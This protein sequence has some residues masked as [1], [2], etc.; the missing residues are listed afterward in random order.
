MMK[1]MKKKN[2]KKPFLKF[3]NIFFTILMA[4]LVFI[5]CLALFSAVWYL[6]VFGDTG[7]ES[8][9][10]TLLSDLHSTSSNIRNSFLQ[11]ALLQTI[12]L[13]TV[14]NILLFLPSKYQIVLTAFKKD[15]KLYP[16]GK[17]SSKIAA[18]I[19]CIPLIYYPAGEVGMIDYI[20]TQ[21]QK[22][23]LYE[24]YYVD[25]NN[26]NITFPEKK[27]NLIYIFLESME[28]SFFSKAENGGLE[29][30]AIPELY[31]LAKKNINFSDNGSVGGA[32][33]TSCATWTVAAMTAQ[34]SGIPLCLP[35][36]ISR[37]S[38]SKYSKF[39][40]GTTTLANILD[41]NGYD[42]AL[43]VG[44]DAN[45]GGRRGL[46]EQ[47]GVKN[48]CDYYTAKTDQ[49]IAPNY[50]VWWGFEDDKLFKY[51]RKKLEQMSKA[52]KPFALTLLT[53]DTHFVG[54]YTCKDCENKFPNKYENVY[55]CSSK[56]V[57]EFVKWIKSQDFYKDTTIIISGD[58]LTMDNDYASNN[59]PVGYTRHIYNCFINSK[60]KAKNSVTKNRDFVTLDMFPTTLAAMGCTIE[61]DRLG[62]GTNLFSGK[63]TLVEQNGLEW[64]DGEIDKRSPYYMN[65][66]LN[67]Y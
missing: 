25:P 60:T 14:I 6:K 50:K 27:Q 49:I 54:G 33:V 37:N 64:L 61:G 22:T 51:S 21:G 30:N 3:I 43:V 28:T 39:L 48:I 4:L 29:H 10:F 36:T 53:V 32:R 46:Y 23:T 65:N 19:V 42:Q 55:A 9:M 56:K 62:L 16:F 59:F 57:N 20:K 12:I 66:F 40:P 8:I 35:G 31:N 63:K 1:T 17:I 7:F 47:H 15:I 67:K 41:K 34:S 45:F 52:D 13:S 58:H 38:Y 11:S 24:D 26:V 5:C 44:S 2:N 18:F